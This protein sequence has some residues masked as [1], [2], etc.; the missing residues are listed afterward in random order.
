MCAYGATATSH[1]KEEVVYQ[2]FFQPYSP[3]DILSLYD[4]LRSDLFVDFLVV[5]SLQL[6]KSNS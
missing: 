1:E 3:G 2:L 4:V 5:F 6:L